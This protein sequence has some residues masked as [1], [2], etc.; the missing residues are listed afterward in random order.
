MGWE[1]WDSQSFPENLSG[2][3]G[4]DTLAPPPRK[5]IL[6]CDYPLSYRGTE[7]EWNETVIHFISGTPYL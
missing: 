6:F 7:I 2:N 1:R 5:D 3:M 4:L